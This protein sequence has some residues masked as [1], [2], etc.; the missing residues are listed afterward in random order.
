MLYLK[1][2]V[3]KFRV[4]FLDDSSGVAA[5]KSCEACVNELRKFISVE[6]YES[7]DSQAAARNAQPST[8]SLAAADSLKINENG[9]C[10]LKDLTTVRHSNFSIYLLLFY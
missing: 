2:F 9:A 8:S 10:S 7:G 4:Q 3:R 5:S 6:A 1:T